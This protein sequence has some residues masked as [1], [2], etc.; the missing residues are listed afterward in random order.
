MYLG[1]SVGVAG[2]EQ[3][4]EGKSEQEGAGKGRENGTEEETRRLCS[5]GTSGLQDKR[6]W[7]A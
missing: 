4:K 6:P 3:S 2:V 1:V 7:E 5:L